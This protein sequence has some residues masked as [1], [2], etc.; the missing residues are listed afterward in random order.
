MEGGDRHQA[1]VI[2]PDLHHLDKGSTGLSTPVQEV[3]GA[4]TRPPAAAAAP[5]KSQ[6]IL[7]WVVLHHVVLHAAM[8]AGP[9]PPRGQGP[10]L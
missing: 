9:Q 2:R 8:I 6:R 1:G 10:N 7:N 4:A 3:M 5:E